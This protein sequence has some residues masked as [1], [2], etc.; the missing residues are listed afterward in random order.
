L[1]YNLN[2]AVISVYAVPDGAVQSTPLQMAVSALGVLSFPITFPISFPGPGTKRT[3]G[4]LMHTPRF[5][6]LAFLVSSSSGKL[7]IRKLTATAF[8]HRMEVRS[9]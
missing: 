6:E 4:T 1:E 2:T 7:S 8:H 3:P 5:R 9:L